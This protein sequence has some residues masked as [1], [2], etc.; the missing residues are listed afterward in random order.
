[1]ADRI[2]SGTT[3]DAHMSVEDHIADGWVASVCIV[4][5]GAPKGDQLIKLDAVFEREDLAWESVEALA[6]AE[7]D[8]LK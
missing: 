6:R 3:H 7:L 2:I 8:S 5:K 4:P 1:M